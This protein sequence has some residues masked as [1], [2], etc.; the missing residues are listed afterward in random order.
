[1]S[2]C[3][4]D[5]RWPGLR[6][7][8]ANEAR[9]CLLADSYLARLEQRIT[10]QVKLTP[11]EKNRRAK[12]AAKLGSALNELATI[13]HHG[14]SGRPNHRETGNQSGGSD[15]ANVVAKIRIAGSGCDGIF[16][17]RDDR[18]KRPA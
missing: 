5:C 4:P 13:T 12:F 2:N 11:K 16:A 14:T 6:F 1:M 3:L 7:V 17:G 10:K 8:L 9:D 18:S 15:I